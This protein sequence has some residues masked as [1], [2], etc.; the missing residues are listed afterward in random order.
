MVEPQGGSETD[1][2]RSDPDTFREDDSPF[3]E[4]I[5]RK[6]RTMGIKE[7]HI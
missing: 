1:L 2:C 5:C 3:R 4:D 6:R 7:R